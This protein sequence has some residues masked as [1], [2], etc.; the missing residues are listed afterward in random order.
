M[1]AM[2]GVLAMAVLATCVWQGFCFLMELVASVDMRVWITK[3][4]SRWEAKPAQPC[5]LPVT[6]EE[7]YAC[8]FDLAM[9]LRRPA[10]AQLRA[11]SDQTPIKK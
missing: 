3:G 4:L 2:D 1:A 8:L 7:K 11:C 9:G 5:C 10:P 6:Q